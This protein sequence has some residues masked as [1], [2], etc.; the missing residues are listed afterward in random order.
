MYLCPGNLSEMSRILSANADYS[1]RPMARASGKPTQTAPPE[2]VN[3]TV[4]QHKGVCD[5]HETWQEMI[6]FTR[7]RNVS[8]GDQI[9]FLQHHPVYTRGVRCHDLPAP[10]GRHIPVVHSD[11]GGLMTWHGPGQLIVYLLLNVRKMNIGPKALVRA[12]EQVTID[13]LASWGVRGARRPGAP[14]VYVQGKKIAA[15]GLRFSRGY[16]YHGLSLNIDADL[17]PYNW[18]VPCGIEGLSVTRLQ[19]QVGP[20]DYTEAVSRFERLLLVWLESKSE[21]RPSTAQTPA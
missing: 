10:A 5:Y 14:G 11:R 17:T 2:P 12:L 20:V 21:T 7:A 6:E 1:R 15:L 13:F 18:I 9:W 3:Y 4:I 8:T 19:D 16:C